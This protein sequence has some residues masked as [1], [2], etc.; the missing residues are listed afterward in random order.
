MGQLEVTRRRAPATRSP[1]LLTNDVDELGPGQGQYTLIC[2]DDGGVI[3][4]L[5]VYALADRFLLVVNASNVAACRE[6]LEDRLPA[7]V[8]LADRSPRG[9]DARPPGPA[10][11]RGAPPARRDAAR[12]L[13][14]LLR[15][16]ART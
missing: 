14:R 4:D 6:R 11:G 2:E 7:G 5:I 15:D 10:L 9:G 1:A 16:R 8:E 12:V 13:A 3:D